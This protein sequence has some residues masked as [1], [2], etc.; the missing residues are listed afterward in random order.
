MLLGVLLQSTVGAGIITIS[1]F[2]L[3]SLCIC[4][5][6]AKTKS[7]GTYVFYSVLLLTLIVLFFVYWPKENA[8]D[9]LET[10]EDST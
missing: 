7:P 3:L 8:A 6:G 4:Y 5:C 1:V 2:A 10:A 9:D